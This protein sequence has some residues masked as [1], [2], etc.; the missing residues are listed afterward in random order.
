LWNLLYSGPLLQY[1]DFTKPF[2]VNMDLRNPVTQSKSRNDRK[3]F[4]IAYTSRLLN[5]TE[6]NYSTIEIELFAIVYSV[7][8]CWPYIYA[9]KL[10]LITDHQPLKWLYSKTRRHIV[11]WRLKSVECEYEVIYKAG[12]INANADA[13]SRNVTLILLLKISEKTQRAT[14]S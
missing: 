2:M 10:T 5:K 3:R 7:Q 1:S 6:Q 12:K 4:I 9:R 8:F 13:L 11:R 14:S